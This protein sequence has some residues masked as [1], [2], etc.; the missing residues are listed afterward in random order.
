MAAANRHSSLAVVGMIAVVSAIESDGRWVLRAVRSS[1]LAA[2]AVPPPA[3]W[4]VAPES[5][6]PAVGAV[7]A[8]EAGIYNPQ[9]Q[10]VGR[11]GGAVGA[12]EAVAH[13]QK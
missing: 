5:L 6:S 3:V 1:E 7:A 4:A 9:S 12:P 8:S 13:H 10:E 11:R 2:R